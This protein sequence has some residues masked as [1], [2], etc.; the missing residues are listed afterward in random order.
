MA[1]VTSARSESEAS[2]KAASKSKNKRDVEDDVPASDDEEGEE[3]EG[4][5]YEIEEVLDAKRGYFPDGRMG[6]FVKWKGYEHS[7][8]S[9]VDE[10]DATNAIDLVN[11]Y[12]RKNPPKKK[13]V[14]AAKKSPKKGRKSAGDEE[15]SEAETSSTKK[16]GR[17]SSAKKG[18]EDDEMDVDEEAHAPKK[19]KKSTTQAAKAKARAPD[20]PEAEEPVIGNMDDYMHMKSWEALVKTVDTIEKRQDQSLVVYFTLTTNEAVVENLDVCKQRFPQK[21]LDFFESNLR[22]RTIDDA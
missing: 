5:E 8:N 16:R 10:V 22:W 14:S 19:A 21:L 1:G 3:D 15:A 4:T 2:N 17:K 11:E 7:E 6:Y 18:E 13:V 12:W 9:W 20:T